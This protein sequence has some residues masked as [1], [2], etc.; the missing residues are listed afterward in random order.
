MSEALKPRVQKQFRILERFVATRVAAGRDVPVP[1]GL[2]VFAVVYSEW[3]NQEPIHFQIDNVEYSACRAD[4]FGNTE[5][6]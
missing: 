2:K 5:A 1:A 3:V 6:L 4:F